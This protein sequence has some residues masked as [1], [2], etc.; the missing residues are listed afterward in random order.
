MKRQQMFKFAKDNQIVA[1][2]NAKTVV[3]NLG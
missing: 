1:K 2:V 3:F